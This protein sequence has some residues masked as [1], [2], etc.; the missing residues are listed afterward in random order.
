MNP[1]AE[2]EQHIFDNF[3]HVA[4]GVIGRTVSTKGEPNT[5]SKFQFWIAQQ[6]EKRVTLEIGNIVAA[7][8]DNQTDICFGSVIEMRSYSDVDSFIAD[9]LSHDFGKAEVNVPT[10]I[11]E[12]VVVTC[13]VMR[14]LSNQTKPIERSRV[15]FPS[16]LGIQFAYGI[17]DITGE[18][19]YAGAAIPLGIFEN[20]DGTVAPIS[21]DENFLVGP[22]GAHLNVSGISGLASKTS[23][24]EFAIKSLLS[25]TRRN[26]AVVM[27]NVKSS[28]LLY[29]DQA[30][31][32]LNPE[33][34]SFDGWSLRAYETLGIEPTPFEGSR[35]FAPTDP[36]NPGGANTLRR[37]Q[38]ERF[39]W[40]LGMIYTDIPTLFNAFDWDDRIEAVWFTIQD[41]I[42]QGRILTYVQMINWT[43]GQINQANGAR[44]PQQ[45]IR[46]S[47][48]ATW[49]KML[50]HLR[51]FP[52]SYSGL[53]ATAG[54]GQNIPWGELQNGSVF[55]ID[56]Q[57]L[58][59]R[60]Q[61]LV[62]G[63]SMRALSDTLEAEDNDLDAIVVFVD[64]LNKFAPSGNIRTPLKSR[65]ID[66]T[67][68]GRSL[69]L[70]L[71]GAEQFASSVDNEIVE[72]S[73]TYLFGRTET[74]ELR[75]PNYSAFSDEVKAKLTM[76]PQGRLLAKSAK[77]SQPI[78]LRFPFPPCLPGDHFEE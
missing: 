26:I 52:R 55:V 12:V 5:S 21:V 38:T 32:K 73:S 56:L 64:E 68:R 71:F 66:I 24:I 14:N 78:F 8:S 3:L 10:D 35:F 76:L 31:P 61:R 59:D 25:N 50:G 63:R 70:V 44:P 54:Q 40:D 30:N 34:I 6:K 41:E 43:E 46:G 19:I 22:E 36:D 74:N 17:V 33:H 49:N 75:N 72:N 53:I 13:A 69:G 62:F 58:G 48:I 77:F 23:A 51:R 20:G 4:Y 1:E 60:G 7:Y 15:Y 37:L 65:L 57:S 39:E 16:T 29:I 67:A 42:E 47:H 27:F 45:W 2:E 28:D 11:S 9:Y 18:T